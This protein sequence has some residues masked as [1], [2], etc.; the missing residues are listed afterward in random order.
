MNMMVKNPFK[1]TTQERE[2]LIHELMRICM[3]V[4]SRG[5]A[6]AFRED[7][8]MAVPQGT[9]HDYMFFTDEPVL[10]LIVRRKMLKLVDYG[11]TVKH[12][13][14]GGLTVRG[15]GFDF[16]ICPISKLVDIHTAW[17]LM[18][19]FGLTKDQAWQVMEYMKIDEY[20]EYAAQAEG[21]A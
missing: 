11:F 9:D 19:R 5:R 21:G 3:L 15:E 2:K 8:A 16:S 13:P 1:S 4:G 20:K 6:L 17:D 12:R 14:N 7:E 18:K 10:H